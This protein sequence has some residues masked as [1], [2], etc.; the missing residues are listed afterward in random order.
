MLANSNTG[1]L[2]FTGKIIYIDICMFVSP[3]AVAS[4]SQV[5]SFHPISVQSSIPK[6]LV[7]MIEDLNNSAAGHPKVLHGLQVWTL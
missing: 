5:F 7:I 4:Y 1:K 3:P 6:Y 2:I